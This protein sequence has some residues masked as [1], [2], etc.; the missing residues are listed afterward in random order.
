MSPLDCGAVEKGD[1]IEAY[2]REALAPEKAEE[3]ERHYLGCD[4]CA[5]DLALALEVRASL[6][7]G[8]AVA[9]GLAQRAATRSPW[10]A[11]ALAAAAAVA[12]VALG[13]S[14]VAPGRRVVPEAPGGS[15]ATPTPV[16]RGASVPLEVTASR[17]ADGS[18]LLAWTAVP[19]AQ[20]YVVRVVGSDGTMLL[21]RETRDTRLAV[22]PARIA[23][24]KAPFRARVKAL[25]PLGYA[26]GESVAVPF[27]EP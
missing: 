17:A 2:L 26:V 7:G 6:R 14:L 21:E 13:I 25:S 22:E 9:T 8:R 5:A 11:H 16:W 20:T 12:F 15:P 1:L 4:R 10:A 27:P 24:A 3:F 19:D 23:G 18:V